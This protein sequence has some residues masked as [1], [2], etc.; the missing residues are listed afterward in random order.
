MIPS[1]GRTHRV[2]VLEYLLF[3]L[4]STRDMRLF[5]NVWFNIVTVVKLALYIDIL[6]FDIASLQMGPKVSDAF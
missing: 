1:G 6:T 3:L 5:P 4:L 2:V